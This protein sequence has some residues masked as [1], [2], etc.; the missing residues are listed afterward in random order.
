[1]Y[2]YI[3][4]YICVYLI[5]DMP[6][7]ECEYIYIYIYVCI[8]MYVDVVRYDVFRWELLSLFDTAPI[9]IVD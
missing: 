4:I 1:M 9:V 5:I 6:H 2:R 3:C 8:C 7:R